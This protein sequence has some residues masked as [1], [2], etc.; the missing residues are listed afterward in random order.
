MDKK[1]DLLRRLKENLVSFLD[2]LCD[3]F[4]FEPEF[5]KARVF[6]QDQFPI[7][8]IM[9]YIVI[10]L[11]PHYNYVKNKDD[12]FFL[13]NN[14][15]FSA[16]EDSKINTFASI[17]KSTNTDN[18]TRDAIWA[19]FLKLLNISKKYSELCSCH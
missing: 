17:W 10:S 3:V 15:L 11:L 6:I 18:H 13:E 4:P 5:I 1:L 16:I 12:K 19:W 14:V 7:E 9:N 8:E 2:E